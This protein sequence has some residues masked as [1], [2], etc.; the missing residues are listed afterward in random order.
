MFRLKKKKAMDRRKG[1]ERRV[2]DRKP[3][4]VDIEWESTSGRR[5]GTINDI[6]HSGCFVL[7]GGEVTDGE[8]V[9]LFIPLADG[10]KVEFNGEVVN[11]VFEIGFA[12]R[13]GSMSDAQKPIIA[14]LIAAGNK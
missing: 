2:I 5:N 13:F 12:V 1:N 14:D 11:H 10:M 8:S 7:S 4:S 3:V 9:R 6:S